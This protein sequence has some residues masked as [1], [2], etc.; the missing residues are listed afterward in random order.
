MWIKDIILSLLFNLSFSGCLDG[1]GSLKT[2]ILIQ[3]TSCLKQ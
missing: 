1:L 2:Q 3:K